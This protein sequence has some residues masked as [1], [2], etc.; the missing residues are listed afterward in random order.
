MFDGASDHRVS[1]AL[2]LRDPDDN[3][4]ELYLD[5]PQEEWPRW[6][7]DWPRRE[8]NDLKSSCEIRL[9]KSRSGVDAEQVGSR[10][11]KVERG[12]RTGGRD[13]TTE[14]SQHRPAYPV[15]GMKIK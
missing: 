5:R 2:Y 15:D 12:Q 14:V 3:G 8:E 13:Q 1:E 4:V 10:K 7:C 9:D 6:R 11:A